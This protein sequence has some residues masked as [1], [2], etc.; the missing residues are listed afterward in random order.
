MQGIMKGISTRSNLQT[1]NW[2]ASLSEK[3]KMYW[4]TGR[5]PGRPPFA[6]QRR[7]EAYDYATLPLHDR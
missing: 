2:A 3:L 5:L 1:N 7:W 4:R 6:P